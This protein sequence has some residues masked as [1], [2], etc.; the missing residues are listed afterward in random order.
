MYK[1]DCCLL[2]KFASFHREH[3]GDT[4]FFRHYF[5]GQMRK[6]VRKM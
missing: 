2:C 1:T 5:S 6:K 4:A 3:R